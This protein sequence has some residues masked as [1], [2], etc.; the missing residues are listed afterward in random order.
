MTNETKLSLGKKLHP[1]NRKISED[2]KMEFRRLLYDDEDFLEYVKNKKDWT[3]EEHDNLLNILELPK[4][5]NGYYIDKFS[6]RVSYNGIRTLKRAH[7]DLGLSPLHFVEQKK[8]SNDYKY[9]RKYYC[10]IITKDGLKR[11][12]P[13]EYQQNL[14][15]SL[16]TLEDTVI[17]YPRQSGKTVTTGTYL[18]W[19]ALN[20]NNINIGIVANKP[21][22]A[23]EVLDKIKKIFIELPIWLQK[24]IEVWNKGDIEFDNGTRVMTDGPSE[25]S[26]RGYTI[27]ILYI[28]EMAYLKK[29]DYDAFADSV[30]PTMSSL[31]WKQFIA[32]STANGMNFFADLVKLA[33][34][35]DSPYRY[36]TVS[37]T[38]IP[39]YDKK[40]NRMK[41]EDY[42][43]QVIQKFG[44]KY[45]LQVEACEFLGSSDTL[46]DGEAL[47]KIQDTV[48]SI[49]KENL[50]VTLFDGLTVFKK[51]IKNHTYI[52]S[53]DSSKDGI[54]D[55]S[56][57]VMDITQFPFEQV[58]DANLQVD[59][60]TMPEYLKELGEYYNNALMVIENNEGSG[61]SISDTLWNVY[62]YEN[63]YRDKK[64][65]GQMGFK[66]YTGFRT[67]VKSRSVILGLLRAF[68]EEEKLVVYSETTL[69]QL[70]TFTKNDNE[71][72]EAQDGYK[73]DNVM[74][75][76]IAFA[77]FMESVRFDDY[78]MF[79]KQLRQEISEAKTKDF[80][81]VLDLA[82]EDDGSEQRS[83][84]ER[85]SKRLK[86]TLDTFDDY[87][88]PD[89]QEAFSTYR[90]YY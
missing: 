85:E 88:I 4:N 76:A 36:E 28:D 66:R 81:S 46:I 79:V 69:A 5:E 75:L 87:G 80:M 62:S 40:G 64:L 63:M 42:K 22:T 52:C 31:S 51:P 24:G 9:F 45:F 3:Y 23:R 72:Y 35:P 32:T 78:E 27:N 73:D 34:K 11:P 83:Y 6:E 8:T 71:K 89:E 74:A 59:Y 82:F 48:Y 25:N 39:R 43:K 61:Q 13:R 20:K 19:R 60:L 2:K 53:V 12:E 90:D 29:K 44:K 54:D 67:T 86:E 68:L 33:K 58:A 41:P 10:K 17:L 26:F 16:L 14:E 57:Q 7:T 50:P 84:F 49:D 65:E 38:K 15:D 77:P 37:W 21:D 70:Y 55:F 18:L 47:K 30:F 56:I 1:K